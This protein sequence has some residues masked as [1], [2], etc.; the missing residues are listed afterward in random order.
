MNISFRSLSV[1]II[2]FRVDETMHY[3][4][5]KE[6]FEQKTGCNTPYCETP[7]KPDDGSQFA[8]CPACNNPVQI[9]GLYKKTQHTDKPFARHHPSSVKD[10][11]KYI[12]EN[13]D[14][15]PL[16]AK[17]TRRS[18]YAKRARGNE[19]SMSIIQRLVTEFDKIIYYMESKIGIFISD[20]LAR[21]MLKRYFANEGYRFYDSS[22]MNIPIKFFHGSL[23]S[24]GLYGRFVRN[25]SLQKAIIEHFPK[26][27]FNDNRLTSKNNSYLDIEFSFIL[28]KIHHSEGDMHETLTLSVHTRAEDELSALHIFQQVI[29]FEPDHYT[30]LVNFDQNKLSK[31]QKERSERLL[32]ISKEVAAYFKFM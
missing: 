14:Y 18:E 17:R 26:A 19:L 9:I 4:I 13:Y 28:H 7:N 24:W 20:N 16:R 3:P 10:L 27:E 1:D 5:E 23:K 30:N 11:A 32:K 15:C 2:K 8:V 25:E 21:D 22:L 29:T 31:K 12:Q 6:L